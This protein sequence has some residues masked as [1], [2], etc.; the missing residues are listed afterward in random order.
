MIVKY[1]RRFVCSSTPGPRVP[2]PLL[3]DLPR[4]GGQAAAAAAGQRPPPA[5]R[6]YS[7][8]GAAA[9]EGPPGHHAQQ[10]GRGTLE[11]ATNIHEFSQCLEKA[12]ILS[13]CLKHLADHNTKIITFGQYG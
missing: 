10:A 7:G 1:S 6:G 12:P 2:R 5:G 11:L 8:Q 4:A 13:P 3:P 9:G